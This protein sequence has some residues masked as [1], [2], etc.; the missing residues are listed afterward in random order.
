MELNISKQAE[1]N[2]LNKA[3]VNS[4]LNSAV[5]KV[6][7]VNK[8]REKYSIVECD[9]NEYLRADYDPY[10]MLEFTLMAYSIRSKYGFGTSATS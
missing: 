8:D 6:V 5:R 2:H 3:Y 10:K 4:L 9:K 7:G 1:I